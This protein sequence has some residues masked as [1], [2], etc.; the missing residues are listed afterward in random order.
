MI[1]SHTNS[2]NLGNFENLFKKFKYTQNKVL[3]NT[4]LDQNCYLILNEFSCLFFVKFSLMF[5]LQK[6]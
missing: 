5:I 2:L 4:D 1:R 3:K 6:A